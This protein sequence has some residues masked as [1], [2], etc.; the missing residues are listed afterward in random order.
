MNTKHKPSSAPTMTVS[1]DRG[2]IRY[3]LRI[4]P[5]DAFP[6]AMVTAAVI[7][8]RVNNAFRVTVAAG[9][10]TRRV[11]VHELCQNNIPSE[12]E[13]QAW[14]RECVRGAEQFWKDVTGHA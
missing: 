3:T 6:Q 1:A 13:A 5:S 2:C 8:D 4:P 14:A 10:Q 12:I 7:P 9:S 11:I